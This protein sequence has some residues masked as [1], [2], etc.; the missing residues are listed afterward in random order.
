MEARDFAIESLAEQGISQREIASRVGCDQK[1]VS[2]IL[3]EE[4]RHDAKIPQPEVAPEEPTED[5]QEE[6]PSVF[7]LSKKRH[8]AKIGHS[9]IIPDH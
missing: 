6:E 2:N 4:K 1:T 7:S 5:A 3:R 8:D 9:L